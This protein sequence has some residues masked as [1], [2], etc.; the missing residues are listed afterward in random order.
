[1]VDRATQTLISLVLDPVV[2]ELSDKYS[3]GFRKH[4]SVH[5]AVSRIRYLCDK[6]YSPE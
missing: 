6:S 1:M 5:D 3:Y 4:K 2:E